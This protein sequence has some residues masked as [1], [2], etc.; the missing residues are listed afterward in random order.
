[1]LLCCCEGVVLLLTLGTKEGDMEGEK[2]G[3][4]TELVSFVLPEMSVSLVK[5]VVVSVS[6]TFINGMVK[7]IN[8]SL[9]DGEGVD[10]GVVVGLDKGVSTESS[11]SVVVV[12]VVVEDEGR[13]VTVGEGEIAE[14]VGSG[15]N[16]DEIVG[17]GETVV[18]PSSFEVAVPVVAAAGAGD[19]LVVVVVVVG[20]GVMTIGILLLLMLLLL[21]AVLTTTNGA[22][23]VPAPCADT[24]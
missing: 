16:D 22:P 4:C 9:D 13:G 21:G 14:I 5:V 1:M 11:S 19:L 20:G 2:E 8:G 10:E 3:C 17:S 12:V 6:V 18:T 23:P 24:C 7:L 15:D